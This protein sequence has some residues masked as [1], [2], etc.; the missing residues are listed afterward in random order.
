MERGE[1]SF[2]HRRGFRG[3]LQL[4]IIM[5]TQTIS[6]EPE[7]NSIAGKSKTSRFIQR[8]M[9]RWHRILGIV[10]VI[11]V[12][13]WTISGLMHP[14]MSHW[15]KPLI[16]HESIPA[17]PLVR[18]QMTR[19]LVEIL[20]QNQVTQ[21]KNFRL[22]SFEKNAY[23]QIKT[24]D[25]HLLY[26]HA[27]T[28][29]P[30]HNGDTRYAESLA[31]YLIDDYQSPVK[32]ITQISSFD[33]EYKFINRLLPVWKVSFDRPD[34]MDVMIETEQSRLATF[35]THSRKAFIWIF[36]VFHN[37]SF[38]EKISNNTVRIIVMLI[39]LS[40]IGLSALSGVVIYGFLWRRFK[41]PKTENTVGI[42]KKYHRQLGIAVALVT[43]TFA[44]SGGWHATRKLT[45]DQRNQFVYEP[46]FKTTELETAS[47]PPDL[48]WERLLNIQL[49]KIGRKNYFQFFYD[50]TETESSE[51]VYQQT[52]THNVLKEGTL[53]YSKYLATKFANL[54]GISGDFQ[55]ACC[56]A[57]SDVSNAEISNDNIA[58]TAILTRFDGEYG[59]VN[60]RLPVVRL[61]YHTAQ[62]T[63]YYI[64]PAT[65]RLA[66]KIENAD[67]A[68]GWSFAMLHKYLLMEWAGKNVRDSVTIIS[69]LG[70][71]VVSLFGLVL[72][73]KRS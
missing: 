4:H 33:T 10:T 60:K 59:F 32:A 44:F 18:E 12:I 6:T 19:S 57:M 42:L 21:F 64:E 5:P 58:E 51:V 62:A 68:E 22:V 61:A 9:Y 11:P 1:K 65:S 63:T 66:A 43:F 36:D 17:K 49:V 35:N 7:K 25:N 29:T 67:R 45:P 54:S 13:F 15:F 52:E 8:N 31:R 55:S 40:I 24:T 38:L 69:A 28:G 47:F 53:V 46:V 50:K 39:L 72:F 71:L 37:W 34:G 20:K 23:Y 27:K 48:P 2:L 73:L 70:V 16:A 14:F 56:D 30:L 26:F 3:G 41:K